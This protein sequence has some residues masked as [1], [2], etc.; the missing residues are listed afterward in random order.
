MYLDNAAFFFLT[1]EGA[2]PRKA[3]EEVVKRAKPDWYPIPQESIPHPAMQVTRR[4]ECC[5]KTIAV[6]RRK[7]LRSLSVV[8]AWR[9][10]STESATRSARFLVGSVDAEAFSDLSSAGR[11]I[12]HPYSLR[13]RCAGSAQPP[14]RHD[15][16]L[17]L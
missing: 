16:G 8:W 14:D 7:K 6:N 12:D 9:S 3:Y 13:D 2:K 15:R 4:K 17:A 11:D 10:S 1:Q 5:H